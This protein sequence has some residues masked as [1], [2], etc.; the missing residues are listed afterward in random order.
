MI[1]RKKY[2]RQLIKKKV[3]KKLSPTEY[4]E[5]IAG[6]KIYTDEE[7]EEMIADVLIE[8][9]DVLP[10]DSLKDWKP[11]FEEI[12]SHKDSSGIKIVKKMHDFEEE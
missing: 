5:L 12:R 9:H 2:I 3:L 1:Y 7:Y 6:R 8:L 10:H 4:S 11:D